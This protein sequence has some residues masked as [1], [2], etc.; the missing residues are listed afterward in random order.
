VNA[1]AHV[2]RKELR[3][4]WRQRWIAAAM[5][6]L[7]LLVTAAL[8]S[9][10]PAYRSGEAWKAA[11]ART[12]RDQWVTQGSRHPH[13]AAHFGIVAFRPLES[14]ALIEPGVSRFVGQM[15]PLETH[16]RAFAAW[17]PAE[18]ATSASRMGQL[19]PALLSL[20]LVPL[21]I[22]II[23]GRAI[24]GER[25]GGNLSVLLASGVSPRGLV[26]GK[27][28]ALCVVAAVA[29]V[30]TGAIEIVALS[31]SGAGV[32]IERFLGLRLVHASYAFIWVCLALG[33]S[34]R[35]RSSQVALSILLTLWLANS[36]V[37]PR[38]AGSVG[39]LAVRE[40][41]TEEFRAA[42]QHDIAYGPDGTPWAETWSKQLIAATLEKH[43]VQRIEDLPVG[44]A[45]V[46]LKGS[47]ARYEA[48]F[49]AHFA[50]LHAIHRAQEAWQHVLSIVGPMI[51]ARSLGQTYAGTD[52]IHVQ[53]FSDAAE[54]YRR[55]FVEATNDAIEK[56]TTGAGWSL[57]LERA[58]WESIP[59]FAYEA[60]GV[61]ETVRQHAL[62]IGVLAG[63][64]II[65]AA[66]CLRSH[67][68]VRRAA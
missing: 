39:R 63:W 52:L 10:L 36:L 44:Y 40:P 54:R 64:T 23:G 57:R 27:T 35:V 50:R 6:S 51:A 15:I 29:M 32:P 30:A 11:A 20:T 13:A 31:L 21:I 45:G 47:D 37:L 1:A 61:R 55:L 12:V 38:V 3:E 59:A 25:E 53:H 41:S 49:Q 60:P 4:I 22:A 68:H 58:F 62:S 34:A 48:V 24:S 8:A 67:A 42:I 66:W 2:L 16:Q 14:T 28:V 56:R 7:A 65:A 26:V 18:D 46:M 43:G 17:R 19:S 9:T 5:G 33:V